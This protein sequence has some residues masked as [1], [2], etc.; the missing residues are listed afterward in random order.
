MQDNYKV[1][2]SVYD[3]MQYDVPYEFW[4]RKIT[5]E[6]K[7]NVNGA[8]SVLEL[9]CGTGTIAIGLSKMGFYVEG[10]DLS[11]DMLAIAQE[12]AFSAGKNIKFLKQDMRTL[13]M[14]RTYE[15]VV[16]LCDGLNYITDLESLKKVFQ[17]VDKHL[18]PGGVFIF[19]LST[20]FKLKEIIGNHT[21]AETFEEGAYIWENQYDEETGVLEFWLTLF[22]E[23][24][25][26]YH[27]SEEYHQQK[28]YSEKLVKSCFPP[29]FEFLGLYD[30]D[31]FDALLPSS[32]RM[33]I[34]VKKI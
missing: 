28:S 18:N 20:E 24:E 22:V 21:F 16:C 33:C 7:Q 34:M 19:D 27:R 17:N 15:A 6:I 29:S 23:T 2:A 26:V 10:C 5:E 13:D 31:T 25:G 14:R 8:R 3:M 9:A 1:F 12:K 4:I 30:G 32:E 11:E